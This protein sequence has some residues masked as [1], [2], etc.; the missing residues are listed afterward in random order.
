[1]NAVGRST[2]VELSYAAAGAARSVEYCGQEH[3]C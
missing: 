3:N 2:D 1:M